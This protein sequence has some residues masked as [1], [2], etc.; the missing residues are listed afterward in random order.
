M[1]SQVHLCEPQRDTP[2]TFEAPPLSMDK[3]KSPEPD[4]EVTWLDHVWAELTTEEAKD[5]DGGM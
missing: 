5:Q 4:N 1:V 2:R 3:P